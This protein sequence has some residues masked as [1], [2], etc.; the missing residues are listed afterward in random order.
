MCS[1]EER[2][3]TRITPWLWLVIGAAV[4]L[5]GWIYLRSPFSP[6][7]NG[8]YYLVQ[9]RSILEKGALGIPDMPLTFTLHA[10]FAWVVQLFGTEQAGA[11]SFSVKLLD[12][13]QKKSMLPVKELEEN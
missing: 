1:M 7:M 3:S 10:A 4:A 2:K 12:R 8:A 6:G 9:A 13:G 11:I 5:R